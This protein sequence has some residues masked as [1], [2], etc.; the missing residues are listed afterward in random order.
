MSI[1]L[2]ALNKLV[3]TMNEMVSKAQVVKAQGLE[4]EQNRLDYASQMA[5]ISGL[6]TAVSFEAAGLT[7]DAVVALKKEGLHMQTMDQLKANPATKEKLDDLLS[8]LKTEA[9]PIQQT[10]TSDKKL[11]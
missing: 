5:M 4:V 9:A 6:A 7:S 8:S 10:K 11:N 1:N 2:N 3:Q